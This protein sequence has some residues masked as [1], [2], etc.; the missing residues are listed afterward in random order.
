MEPRADARPAWEVLP[1]LHKITGRVRPMRAVAHRHAHRQQWRVVEYGLTE[2]SH[3]LA[4]AS[5]TRLAD[6]YGAS[7]PDRVVE[8]PWAVCRLGRAERILDAGSTFNHRQILDH[9]QG[10]DLTITTLAPE[11]H[12]Y[13]DEGISYVFSD[14]RDLPF[15]D[16]RFDLVLS[17]SVLEHVGMDVSG[18]GAAVARSSEPNAEAQQAL[19]ELARVVTPGGRILLSVPYGQR[20]DMEWQ[21]QFDRSELDALLNAVHPASTTIS[22]YRRGRFGWQISD[23][24]QAGDCDLRTGNRAVACVELRF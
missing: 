15:R 12:N 22:V 9:F 1:W 16:D 4:F 17:I 13:A 5:G 2:P 18:Y 20:I 3:A 7:W 10:R 14:L 21:R 24:V 19:S 8:F 23:L 11:A 6:G